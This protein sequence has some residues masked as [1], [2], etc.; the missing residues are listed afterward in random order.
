MKKYMQLLRVKHYIKNL[1]VFVPLFFGGSLF[2]PRKL[3]MT[4]WGF[5]SFCL[6]SSAVYILNDM[7]DYEKDRNHPVKC[8]RPLASGKISFKAAGIILSICLAASLVISFLTSKY[9]C[10]LLLLLYFGL[11]VVYSRGGK[12]IP[13]VDV[14]IL[15]SGFVIRTFFGG[16]VSETEISKWLYLVIVVGSLYLGLGKRRNE[17]RKH[18]DT[19]DVLKHYTDPFLDKNMYVCVAMANVFYALWAIEM[20]SCGMIWT[21]PVFIIIM[22]CYSMDIERDV[23]ADPTDVILHDKVLLCL[24]ALLAVV[25]F[26]LLYIS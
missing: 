11:N 10:V 9:V 21:V 7:C 22:M 25:L 16:F 1:L 13:I 20:P 3:R 12:K 2:D 15:A 18:T 6:V 5:L 4:F 26:I 24:A 23:D 8:S 17:L 14:V 19:R